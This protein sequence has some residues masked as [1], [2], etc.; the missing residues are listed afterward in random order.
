MIMVAI[1]AIVV[2]S[3]EAVATT[4]VYVQNQNATTIQQRNYSN[5]IT[6]IPKIKGLNASTI[7]DA[8]NSLVVSKTKSWRSYISKRSLTRKTRC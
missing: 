5:T 4:I 7:I 2:A 3:A 8:I 6:A 1:I